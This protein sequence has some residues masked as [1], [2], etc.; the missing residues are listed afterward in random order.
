[1]V[2]HKDKSN[3]Q[4]ICGRLA[5]FSEEYFCHF[6]QGSE[7]RTVGLYILAQAVSEIKG[8]LV[9]SYMVR[10]IVKNICSICH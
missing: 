7:V 1:M 6:S 9:L 4:C 3:W 5:F 10:L 8:S 2:L